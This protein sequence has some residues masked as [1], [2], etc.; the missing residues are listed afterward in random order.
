MF[1]THEILARVTQ[2]R[3]APRPVCHDAHALQTWEDE[4]GSTPQVASRQPPLTTAHEAL[5][6]HPP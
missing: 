1:L 3:P 6:K 4:G 5:G 2:E